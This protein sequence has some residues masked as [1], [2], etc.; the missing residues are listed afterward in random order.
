MKTKYQIVA[1][2][3]ILAS[4][5]LVLLYNLSGVPAH[6]QVNCNGEPQLKDPSNP[7]SQAYAPGHTFQ[8]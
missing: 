1:Q 7:K 6:A 4:C 3:V 8:R 2:I 5:A